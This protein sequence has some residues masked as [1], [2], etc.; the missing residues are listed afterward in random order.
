M[1]SKIDLLREFYNTADTTRLKIETKFCGLP[2]CKELKRLGTLEYIAFDQKVCKYRISG[3]PPDAYQSFLEQHLEKKINLCAYFNPE[4]NAVFAFNLDFVS[5]I[6]TD[7][8]IYALYLFRDLYVLGIFPLVLRSGHGYHFWCKVSE[9]VANTKLRAFM[10]AACDKAFEEAV[11][12]GV[13][14]DL[15]RC[16]RYPRLNTGDISIRLFGSN[17]IV[18]GL[19]S[20]V[21]IRIDEAD[22][23]LNEAD[24]WSYFEKYLREYRIPVSGFFRAC[25][26]IG[27]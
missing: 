9:P 18:T 17:H 1:P 24:S 27:V 11:S 12:K 19:F 20:N 5:A 2:Y 3:L 15:L 10:K 8:K 16:T 14:T 4:E 26:I 13:N 25:E 23:I 7:L 21:V 6:G 22:T